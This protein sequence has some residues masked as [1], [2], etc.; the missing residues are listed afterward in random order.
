MIVTSVAALSE[1]DP[2]V[3]AA[4][5]PVPS[6]QGPI[7]VTADSIP[8]NAVAQQVTTIDLTIHGYSEEEYFL[9]G[10]ANVYN[11]DQ[12]G[13]AEIRTAD[14]PYTNRIVVR[15][16]SDLKKFS[17]NV[18][19][20]IV[21]STSTYDSQVLW[22]GCHDKFLRDGDIYVGITN[23]PI[24]V[25]ALKKYNP[26]RYAPLSWNNPLPPEQRGKNPGNYLPPGV[27]GSVPETED[28]L[29]WDIISQ[30]GALLKSNIQS[31]PLQGYK[32]EK[33]YAIGASQSAVLLT[34]YINAIHP[35]ANMSDG[36]SIFDGYLLTVG[37]YPLQ[38]NQDAT[39]LFPVGDP[40]IMIS[41]CSVP[42]IRFMSQTDFRAMGPWDFLS[43][44]RADSDDLDDRFRLYEVPASSHTT[45]H[46][47][48]YRSG[49]RELTPLGFEIPG[50][51]D[52]F[53]NDFPFQ[54]LFTGGLINLDKWVRE[55]TPPPRAPFIEI[56]SS[57]MEKD[58][59]GN[60]V[61]AIVKD[62][63]GNALG[64]L[65]TPYVDVP[66]ATYTATTASNPL[67]GEMF[68]LD[69]Q[70]LQQLYST[71]EGYMQRFSEKVDEMVR[72]RWITVIE[73]ERMKQEA[74]SNLWRL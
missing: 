35:I 43:G 19:V 33:V 41:H 29:I 32:V 14:A 51:T 54:Y 71:Y 63:F 68:Y 36:K 62:Q 6:V 65:R 49:H 74:A 13:I 60:N 17:G 52:Y 61:P 3:Y 12:P 27:P 8:F 30:A 18:F 44:R 69:Q 7:P 5:V 2:S 21:N 45:L 25:K 31:N 37:A 38:I 20:E 48:N 56:D 66:I 57:V 4:P 58:S 42:V 1:N 28:G 24:A 16:P 46:T 15:K 10:E 70:L 47:I 72:D 22:Y 64:G 73:G 59:F 53:Q 11:W 34:T 67:A 55:G 23:K 39:I 9:S 50:K 40:R 26:V